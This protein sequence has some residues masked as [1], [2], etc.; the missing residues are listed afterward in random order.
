[1]WKPF[2]LFNRRGGVDPEY[3]AIRM[4]FGFRQEAY[5]RWSPG[6]IASNR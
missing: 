5:P 6:Q 1:M 3:S 2:G 4:S